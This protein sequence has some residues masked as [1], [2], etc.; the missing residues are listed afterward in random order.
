MLCEANQ[1]LH[2]RAVI[3]YECLRALRPMDSMRV[4]PARGARV[5][6]GAIVQDGKTVRLR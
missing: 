1:A 4:K 3:P 5:R 6:D 2:R